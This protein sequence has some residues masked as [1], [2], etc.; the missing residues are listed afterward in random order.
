MGSSSGQWHIWIRRYFRI[1][2]IFIQALHYV[3]YIST[4]GSGWFQTLCPKLYF[5]IFIIMR[6]V[7]VWVRAEVKSLIV[8]MIWIECSCLNPFQIGTSNFFEPQS[9]SKL[10]VMHPCPNFKLRYWLLL[11]RPCPSPNP[12]PPISG[13][14]VMNHDSVFEKQRKL[15]VHFFIR[16]K[17]ESNRYYIQIWCVN[18]C[19]F[20]YVMSL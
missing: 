4:T 1:T 12:R 18:I 19:L 6:F 11:L 14:W 2:V 15:L 5:H 9:L 7:S 10:C 17:L 8:P 20:A 16:T 13:S 3:I